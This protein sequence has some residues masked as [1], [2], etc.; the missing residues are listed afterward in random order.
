VKIRKPEDEKFF[1]DVVL[2]DI[3]EEISN[4][5]EIKT[6]STARIKKRKSSQKTFSVKSLLFMA[7]AILLVLF[8]ITL[9][10]LVT[11]STEEVKPLSQTPKVITTKTDAE[12]WKMPE[13]G[14]DYKKITSSKVLKETQIPKKVIKR[15]TIEIKPKKSKPLPPPSLKKTERELAKEALRQ[16]ML[17]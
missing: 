15:N 12:S 9:F 16:Q 11:E 13:D 14:G 5:D 1:K 17:N 4:E 8:I 2:K 6:D 10:K 3:L 7:I